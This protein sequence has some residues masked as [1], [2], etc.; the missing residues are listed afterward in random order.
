MSRDSEMDSYQLNSPIKDEFESGLP[1][2]E[3]WNRMQ[4]QSSTKGCGQRSKHKT[5]WRSTVKAFKT[6][7]KVNGQVAR[8]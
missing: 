1:S 6:L 2:T 7:V 4:L 3:G 8:K 5:G